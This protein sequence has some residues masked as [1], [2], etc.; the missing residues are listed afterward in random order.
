MEKE[1][2]PLSNT[3][4]TPGKVSSNPGP[5]PWGNC[6]FYQMTFGPNSSPQGAVVI[7][8]NATIKS[9]CDTLDTLYLRQCC[10]I[11][12]LLTGSYC[13]TAFHWLSHFPS[14]SHI[15]TA[16]LVNKFAWHK[17]SAS[18]RPP[19]PG[20]PTFFICIIPDLPYQET[21]QKPSGPGHTMTKATYE[22]KNLFGLT[23]P[24][25]MK[26][27]WQRS[28]AA[29]SRLEQEAASSHFGPQARSRERR[30]TQ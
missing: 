28:M 23:V 7:R 11:S 16:I 5:G 30:S 26:L 2:S 25:E 9:V 6:G 29:C 24:K 20:F 12:F 14:A 18:A 8:P 13:T 22:R 3:R 19:G 10:L 27:H 17:P 1:G 21:A 15:K 4:N